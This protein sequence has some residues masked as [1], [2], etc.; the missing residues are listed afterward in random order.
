MCNY[1][2]QLGHYSFSLISSVPNGMYSIII[3]NLKTTNTLYLAKL[4]KVLH[5][6]RNYIGLYINIY[7]WIYWSYNEVHFPGDI[8]ICS[9]KYCVV[10]IY[11][12][13]TY[14]CLYID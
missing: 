5:F 13:Y 8:K 10:L 11:V 12:Y 6:K 1:L 2:L 3:L 7:F 9:K 4:I 14:I